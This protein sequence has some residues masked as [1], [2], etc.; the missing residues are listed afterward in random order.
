MSTYKQLKELLDKNEINNFNELYKISTLKENEDYTLIDYLFINQKKNAKEILLLSKNKN[1]NNFIELMY[2]TL[3][4]L[5]SKYITL[6]E[7][8]ILFIIKHIKVTENEYK[9]IITE[10]FNRDNIHNP[11]LVALID[12]YR[13]NFNINEFINELKENKKID[14]KQLEKINLYFEMLDF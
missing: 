8:D 5:I 11:V 10:M 3:N 12:Q 14:K 1:K 6:S 7:N 9:K 4:Y 13:S 2:I